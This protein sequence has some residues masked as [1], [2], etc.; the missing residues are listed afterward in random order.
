MFNRTLEVDVVKKGK[1]PKTEP[2]QPEVDFEEKA[3]VISNLLEN[4]IKKVGLV[5]CAYVVLDTVRKVAVA[6]VAP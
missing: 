1:T 3:K 2:S 6:S 4:G 5:I